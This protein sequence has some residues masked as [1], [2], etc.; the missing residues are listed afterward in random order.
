MKKV[1][2]TVRGERRNG[3]K[4]ENRNAF[5]KVASIRH[6]A[7]TYMYDSEENEHLNTI[8]KLMVTEIN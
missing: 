6:L 7:D 5:M 2:K 1:K 3:M 8:R 4:N